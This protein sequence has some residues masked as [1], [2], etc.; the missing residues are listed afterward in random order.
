[1]TIEHV[2]LGLL[3]VKPLFGYDLKKIMQESDFMYWSGNNNQIYRSL[4]QLC[5]AG[6]AAITVEHRENAPLLKRYS[7]TEKGLEVL[8]EGISTP[9]SIPEEKT[10]SI[11]SG[12]RPWHGKPGA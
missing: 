11:T 8:K 6:C 3:S 4:L 7:I 12:I 1:M 10:L 9:A 2:I 5:D